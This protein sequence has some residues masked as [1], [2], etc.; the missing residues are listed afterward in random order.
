MHD[1]S[2][3]SRRARWVAALVLA[4]WVAACWTRPRLTSAQ[5]ATPAAADPSGAPHLSLLLLTDGSPGNLEDLV[6]GHAELK[7]P[8]ARALSDLLELVVRPFERETGTRLEVVLQQWTTLR[9]YVSL[10]RSR[11]PDLFQVPST[12]CADQDL[13]ELLRPVE[14]ATK[15]VSGEVPEQLVEACR[16]PALL[17]IPTELDIAAPFLFH[18]EI[19]ARL[20]I[21]PAMVFRDRESF[22]THLRAIKRVLPE[23]DWPFG[24]VTSPDWNETATLHRAAQ[25]AQP[26]TDTDHPFAAVTG[27][28]VDQSS[29]GLRYLLRLGLEGLFELP[30]PKDSFHVDPGTIPRFPADV[31]DFDGFNHS[32]D[33]VDRFLHGEIAIFTGSPFVVRRAADNGVAEKLSAFLPGRET[34]GTSGIAEPGPAPYAFVGGSLLGISAIEGSTSASDPSAARAFLAYVSRPEVSATWAWARGA[35]PPTAEGRVR[36]ASQI[37]RAAMRYADPAVA[38]SYR[39]AAGLG[40]YAGVGLL[41]AYI[42][43]AE[44]V[45]QTTL[46]T[47]SASRDG[48]RP[49][50]QYADSRPGWGDTE[51]SLSFLLGSLYAWTG[52]VRAS[53]GSDSA[54]PDAPAEFRKTIDDALATAIRAAD[55]AD[56]SRPTATAE[57]TSA[58]PPPAGFARSWLRAAVACVI[59]IGLAAIGLFLRRHSRSRARELPLL[60]EDLERLVSPE[61]RKSIESATDDDL[62]LLRYILL[63]AATDLGQ[64]YSE[65]PAVTVFLARHR[66]RIDQAETVSG[67]RAAIAKLDDLRGSDAPRA[68]AVLLRKRR[69]P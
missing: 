69:S 57:P 52:A 67:L 25:F 51:K 59:V 32:G 54:Y 22:R 39:A 62:P 61:L 5:A 26:I 65:V 20:A 21:T 24:V 13:R 4:V 47:P 48:R 10:V 12:W 35:L 7:A 27:G 49:T 38:E 44:S 15:I 18:R 31:H 23:G 56:V 50:V 30:R 29:D 46:S 36:L 19:F 16:S 53:L 8:D 60:P 2:I 40:A 6:S 63:N 28:A 68:R 3:R 1:S 41:D 33:V 37:D 58:P 11:K 14:D 9:D 55:L 17:A 43:A 34:P 64:A 66:I 45:S 42:A